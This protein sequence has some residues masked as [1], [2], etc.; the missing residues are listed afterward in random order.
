MNELMHVIDDTHRLKALPSND[1]FE[2]VDVLGDGWNV[3]TLNCADRLSP[4]NCGWLNDE[5]KSIN[6]RYEFFARDYQAHLIKVYLAI[7]GVE[8]REISLRGYSQGEWHEVIIYSDKA[9]NDASW[10]D[11]RECLE[12]LRAWY[13][14]DVF[15]VIAEKLTTWQN[16]ETMETKTTWEEVSRLGGVLLTDNYGLANLTNELE[17][18]N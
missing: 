7:K 5:L 11:D 12:P 10:M 3:Y 1:Y 18:D 17:L 6:R 4:I 13:R 2:M 16:V 15:D 8:Y 14:G 9:G